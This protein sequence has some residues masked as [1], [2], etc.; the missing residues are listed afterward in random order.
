MTW[1]VSII[2]V[3]V[4][5]RLPS[6]LYDPSA[7]PDALL[8]VPC[9]VYALQ[10]GPT[11]VL[12]D[13]GPDATAAAAAGYDIVGDTHGALLGGLGVLGITTGDVGHIVHTHLHYDHAE[14]DRLFP[15]AE[16]VV[17]VAE[18]ESAGRKGADFYVDVH[19]WHEA[20]GDRLRTISGSSALLPGVDLVLNGGH[21][22]GHQ[23][24]VVATATGPT[25]V[26]GDIVSMAV[27]T[28]VV[29]PVCP[30]AH[31]TEAFLRQARQAG[32]AML[33]SHE[34]ALRRHPWYVEVPTQRRDL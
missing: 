1:R 14:N 19:R 9:Y 32:W 7:A 25:C 12:V 21:T 3:G 2:E 33:P 18:L 26:C 11:V 23:S 27:N 31:A 17:Q 4:I 30:D 29:G 28:Q 24:A 13:S 34:P 8:D 15:E 6:A 5:P 16:V 22:P 20:V 10:A